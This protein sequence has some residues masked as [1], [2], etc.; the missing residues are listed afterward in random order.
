MDWP[1]A[2]V[3][4]TGLTMVPSEPSSSMEMTPPG[5]KLSYSLVASNLFNVAGVNSRYTD[6][7]GTGQTSDQYIA[8]RQ[9]IGTVAYHF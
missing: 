8:P 3:T 2:V 9:L 5:A 1:A 7:F 4:F 6:P